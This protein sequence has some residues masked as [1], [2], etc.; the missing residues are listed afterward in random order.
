MT[1]VVENELGK[2][3]FLV[4]AV[5]ETRAIAASDVSTQATHPGRVAAWPILMTTRDLLSVLDVERLCRDPR[6]RVAE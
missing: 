6:V 3:G 5:I 4:D 2:L 1:V